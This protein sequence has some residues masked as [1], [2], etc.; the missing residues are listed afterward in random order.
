[1]YHTEQQAN[2][3][4]I[5]CFADGPRRTLLN[6]LM[7][8]KDGRGGHSLHTGSSQ[9]ASMQLKNGVYSIEVDIQDFEPGD[10]EIKVEGGSIILVGRRVIKR[11]TSSSIRQF[12]QKFA[13][14]SGID[15]SRLATE[16]TK[17]GNLVIYAPQ[18]EDATISVGIDIPQHGDVDVKS[19]SKSMKTTSEAAFEVDGGSG[20]KKK[21]EDTKKI[22][23]QTVTKRE[24]EDGWEEE[25]I[26][27]YEEVTTSSSSS[28]VMSSSAGGEKKISMVVQGGAGGTQTTEMSTSHQDIKA[29]DG[30]ILEMQKGGCQ[31]SET[32]EIV[33][34][35]QIQGRPAVEQKPK[36][37]KPRMLPFDFPS[38]PSA[39][40]DCTIPSIGI[41]RGTPAFQM[42]MLSA[43]DMMAEMQAQVEQQMN[44]LKRKVND[45]TNQ[46][47]HLKK[48]RRE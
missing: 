36:T 47:A 26:E 35:I 6:S 24:T 45:L 33:I 7:S 48:A 19:S 29:K 1:M 2:Y 12:N 34:P 38:L 39:S 8:L 23:Q 42:P 13:L 14:P 9:A 40:M 3:S 25:I 10:I 5:I 41:P 4:I 46:V 28:T 17:G 16:V 20:T 11:G 44:E 15:V 30:K 18:I 37:P 27:E 21:V 31:K 32:K 22:N 43:T